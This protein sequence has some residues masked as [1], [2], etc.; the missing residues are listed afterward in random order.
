[1]S[2]HGVTAPGTSRGMACSSQL[3]RS[4]CEGIP[5]CKHRPN[6]AYT[7]RR[8]LGAPAG[9]LAPA[10]SGRRH[11]TGMQ[12]S[13]AP[14]ADHAGPNRSR[15]QC[16]LRLLP[17]R[18]LLHLHGPDPQPD[19]TMPLAAHA[20][21]ATRLRCHPAS[22]QPWCGPHGHWVLG[23]SLP[24]MRAP[25]V[26]CKTIL[27]DPIPIKLP[28]IIQGAPCGLAEPPCKQQLQ[29]WHPKTVRHMHGSSAGQ[30]CCLV[31]VRRAACVAIPQPAR[32]CP[33]RL[34]PQSYNC[35]VR[36]PCPRKLC[37]PRLTSGRA[38]SGRVD[39][40]VGCCGSTATAAAS[41]RGRVSLCFFQTTPMP[42]CLG[43]N[44]RLPVAL[45]HI[46]CSSAVGQLLQPVTP[47]AP[48]PEIAIV[49][50]NEPPPH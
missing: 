4:T 48:C 11:R 24:G 32:C 3:R 41:K 29:G 28:V 22:G 34:P 21:A 31:F 14:A 49:L 45:I 42:L 5:A 46:F 38:C 9:T 23:P 13:A 26:H 27:A 18:E 12:E 15:H 10:Q 43:P 19:F 33:C 16:W 44:N 25:Q 47:P 1:M 7:L 6:W 37:N 8:V 2:T 40:D 17:G 30:A 39:A 50:R 35:L 20:A 36:R